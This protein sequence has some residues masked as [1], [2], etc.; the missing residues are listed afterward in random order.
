MDN[1]KFSIVTACYNSQDYIDIAIKSILSQ[2]YDNWELIIIDD[3]SIDETKDIVRKYLFDKR[4]KLFI[5]NKNLGCGGAKRK[6][7]E[8]ATGDIVGI[9]DSD[10]K[11]KKDALT[12]IANEYNK[13]DSIGLV[14]STYYEC[15]Q[16]LNKLRIA[17]WVGEYRTDQSSL[18]NSKISHFL[19]FKKDIYDKTSGIDPDLRIAEDKDLIYKIEEISKLKFIDVPLYYYRLH[20]KSVTFGKQTWLSSAYHALAKYKAFK[21]RQNID[22]ININNK[23][24]SDILIEGSFKFLLAG[25]YKKS[26]YLYRKSIKLCPINISGYLIMIK[27]VLQEFKHHLWLIKNKV[28]KK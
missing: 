16:N 21:R 9:L 2:D 22:I 13:D 26:F 7:V 1:Y 8:Y 25:L 18:L 11:L 10:D 3:A 14:Y 20:D 17:K 5:N 27:R 28:I 23:Q 15:D 12:I 19:T 6:G 24:M 4:I